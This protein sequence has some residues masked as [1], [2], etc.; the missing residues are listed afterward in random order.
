M[1]RL[2]IVDVYQRHIG[3]SVLICVQKYNVDT[4]LEPM[5]EHIVMSVYYCTC[6]APKYVIQM[7]MKKAL[8]LAS[9][10]R[11]AFFRHSENV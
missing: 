6:N 9:K 7:E 3:K 8:L 2:R 4:G 11:V 10:V 5:L 1:Q